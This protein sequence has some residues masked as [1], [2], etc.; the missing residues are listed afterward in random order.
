M[1]EMKVIQTH[2]VGTFVRHVIRTSLHKLDQLPTYPE[3]LKMTKRNLMQIT[4][5]VI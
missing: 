1:K 3:D 5:K 2:F 4:R